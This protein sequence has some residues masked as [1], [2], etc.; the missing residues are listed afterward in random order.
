[1]GLQAVRRLDRPK[2]SADQEQ[3]RLGCIPV[4]LAV[5]C[6]AANSV[7]G[8]AGS[9]FS[10]KRQIAGCETAGNVWNQTKPSRSQVWQ[11]SKSLSVLCRV[12][13]TGDPSRKVW[14]EQVAENCRSPWLL[15][16]YS[17]CKVCATC[18][19]DSKYHACSQEMLR[20]QGMF[21]LVKLCIDALLLKLTSD[22]D[23]TCPVNGRYFEVLSLAESSQNRT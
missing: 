18:Y 12:D 19:L 15:Q 17:R 8:C 16:H 21:E 10:K 23:L 4:S 22:D 13:R 1:M 14:L 20:H 2:R 6:G 3:R 7:I 5:R 11:R 9:T